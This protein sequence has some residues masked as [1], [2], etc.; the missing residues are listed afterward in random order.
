MPAA[1]AC[2][3]LILEHPEGLLWLDSRRNHVSTREKTPAAQAL[4]L[5]A[6]TLHKL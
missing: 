4:V 2:G 5:R 1:P 3:P 6:S